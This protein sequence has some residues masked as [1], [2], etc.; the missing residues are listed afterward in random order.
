MREYIKNRKRRSQIH[1]K[2]YNPCLKASKRERETE[3][4]TILDYKNLKTT[5]LSLLG[6]AITESTTHTKI[7][8]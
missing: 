4:P 2:V 1:N 6:K 8:P 7:N 3:K 5:G